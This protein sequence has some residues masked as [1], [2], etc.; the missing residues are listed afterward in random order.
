MIPMAKKFIYTPD[1][2]NEFHVLKIPFLLYFVLFYLNKYFL[3][4]IFPGL[5]VIGG[6]DFSAI[7]KWFK[8][9]WLMM[10]SCLPALAVLI[11]SLY[12]IP[13]PKKFPKLIWNKGLILLLISSAMDLI[14]LSSYVILERRVFDLGT[15][16]LLLINVGIIVY[17]LRSKYLKEMFKEFPEELEKK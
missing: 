16:I 12:R 8:I 4:V 5:P 7:A 14:V 17:L 10:M 3:L 6:A 13:T 9:D 2:F 15:F 1:D 11:A